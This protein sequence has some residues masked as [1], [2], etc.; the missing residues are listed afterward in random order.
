MSRGHRSDVTVTW[1]SAHW[2]RPW[3]VAREV[4]RAARRHAGTAAAIVVTA[5]IALVMLGGA[6]LVHAQ[7][8]S[9]KGAWYDTTQVAVY[10]AADATGAQ[11]DAVGAALEADPGVDGVWFEDQAQA[12]TNFADQF[13]DSPDLVAEVSAD[14]MPQSY[15]V[16][17][18]DPDAGG[19]VVARYSA[20]PGVRSVVDEHAQLATLFD[21]LSGFAKAALVL[22]GIQAF[23]AVVLIVNMVSSTVVLRA[24]ELR[25]GRVMGA[26]RAQLAVPFL[27]EVAT[28]GLVGSALAVAILAV[29]K[30]ELVDERLATSGVLSGIVGYVGWDALWD[31]V[32]W[33]L[34]A[35]VG[36]PVVLTV[37]LLA[38]HLHR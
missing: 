23:A 20:A 2:P 38:R 34:T 17:L 16:S 4:A 5:T 37:G 24:R 31:T 32:P 18:V 3:F 6:L 33:L 29:A 25:V 1:R 19:D 12:Y 35:G 22:A 28:Y 9:L 36:V 15:R 13:A 14:Q 11:V 27:A 8:D 7:I 21:V 26:T 10:L 30:V